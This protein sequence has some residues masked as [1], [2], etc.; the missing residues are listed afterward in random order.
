MSLEIERRF[1]VGLPLA[2]YAKFRLR[3][4]QLIHIT[5]VYLK[6]AIPS[7][8][9]SHARIRRAEYDLGAGY[10]D[11]RFS[12]TYKNPVSPGVNEEVEFVLNEKEYKDRLRDSDYSKRVIKK[13]RYEIPFSKKKFELDIFQG[14]LLGLAIMEVELES[15]EEEIHLP[16]HFEIIKEI[17]DNPEYSNYRLA[18]MDASG[19]LT[20]AT[21]ISGSVG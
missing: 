14:D 6:D 19:L 8:K 9:N 15:L 17:T 21:L 1:L 7:M 13:D 5:Q 3:R 20:L 16:P 2:W 12:Y 11:I 4:C 18:S 10:T